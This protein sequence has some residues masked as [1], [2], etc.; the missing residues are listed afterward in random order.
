V[1]VTPSDDAVK[2]RT[3]SHDLPVSPAL[4]AFMA[5]GWAPPEPARGTGA[6]PAAPYTVHRRQALAARFPG[7]RLVVPSGVLK[8]R[9]NDTDYRF[10]PHSAFVHLSAAAEPEWCLVLEPH[11]GGHRATLYVRD[12]PARSSGAFYRDRRYGELWVGPSPGL[13]EAAAR[14]GIVAKPLAALADDLAAGAGPVPT[15]L[16]RGVDPSVDALLPDGGG[17]DLEL[18]SALSELRLVK[19]AWEIGEITAAVEATVRGF[20]DVVRALPALAGTP[21][22]ERWVEGVFGLRA[23]REGNGLGYETIAAAGRHAGTL[24]WTRNDGAV[25]VG[26]L[27]LLDAGVEADSL[28][29]ADITRTLPVSGVF[30]P[31]QRKV[32][33]LVYAAQ[34]AGIAAVAPGARFRDFH[35]A[36]MTVI[37][38]GLE[39][40]GL[41]PV[42][43]AQSLAPD[44]G[45]H[46]RYT[47]CSSGHMLGLD[48]HDCAQARAETYLDA[49]LEVGHVLTVE[50]GLYFQQDDLTLPP[51]LRGIGVRIEDDVVVT[52]DG[53]RV[54]S[55]GLPRQAD[56]VQAWMQRL[57]AG[58][59]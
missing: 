59:A 28:H 29:T 30:T 43:A 1:T 47:L 26:E 16:L 17:R 34:E 41:L 31:T 40:W 46:R 35:L 50:P 24:H 48:V 20:E 13:D 53:C 21:R 32:Y 57:W 7:E 52:E 22:G 58:P 9:S 14:Y 36:A 2:I 25:R 12:N 18:A 45:L 10:R 19:D 51:E 4:D 54:L 33:D 39:S 37:A 44:S 27:L 3:G 49:V 5:S 56:A 6:H 42:P 8:A 15:R 55:S 38:H 23:R 11:A